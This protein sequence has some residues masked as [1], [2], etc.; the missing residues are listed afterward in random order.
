LARSALKRATSASSENS[1]STPNDIS[2]SMKW[3]LVIDVLQPERVDEIRRA[4]RDLLT[5][6]VAVRSSR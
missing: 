5:D 6:P 1:A 3:A 4:L 2:R